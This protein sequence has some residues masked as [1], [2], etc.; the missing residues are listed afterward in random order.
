LN[1]S[2]IDLKVLAASG[3]GS[4]EAKSWDSSKVIPVFHRWIQE[5]TLDELMI[6]VADYSHV[7]NGPSVI[8]LCH[9][10]QYAL[11]TGNGELGLLYSRRRETGG[12]RVGGFDSFA[13]RVPSVFHDALV[14]CE[15][16]EAE[17]SLVGELRFPCDRFVLRCNDRLVGE[18]SLQL[19]ETEIRGFME[20]LVP[21]SSTDVVVGVDSSGR[22]AC[23]IQCSVAPGSH[24]LLDRIEALGKE[25][26]VPS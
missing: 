12:S 2:R 8:L 20:R 26:E 11:D 6:D 1:T 9:D 13:Q 3:N 7:P 22:L 25:A 10:A 17:A 19:V 24:A 21:E 23:R 14:V 5:G 15:K 16:L 4:D 18:E